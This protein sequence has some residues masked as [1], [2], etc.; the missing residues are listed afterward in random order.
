[1]SQLIWSHDLL[2]ITEVF[3][4]S[5]QQEQIKRRPQEYCKFLN[6]VNDLQLL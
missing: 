6:L 4:E 3:C 5:H 2:S 1:M